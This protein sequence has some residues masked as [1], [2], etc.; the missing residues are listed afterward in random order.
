MGLT[1]R[2]DAWLASRRVRDGT[3]GSVRILLA[4]ALLAYAWR[5]Q[6]LFPALN[7]FKPVTLITGAFFLLLILD[8]K[9]PGRLVRVAQRP[10]AVFAV[11]V[12]LVA[13]VGIPFSLYPGMS[14][15]VALKDV[16]PTVLVAI[17]IA[18]VVRSPRDA[19]RFAGVHVAGAVVYSAVVLSR[20]SLGPDGRLGDLVYYDANGLGLIM[21]CTLPLAYWYA[22][23]GTRWAARVGAVAAMPLFLIAIIRSGSRGALLGLVTVVG[24]TL[25]ANRS[26]TMRTRAGLAAVAALLLLGGGT[27]YWGMMDTML[28]PTRDY[29]WVGNAEGGRMDVW[30]R[31]IGY[32]ASHPILGVGAGAFPVAEGTISPLAGRQDYGEGLKWSA[33]HNSFVQVGAELGV[34]GLVAFLAFLGAGFRQARRTVR[35]ARLIGDLRAAAMGDALAAS[36]AGFAVS[37]FFLS[38]GYSPLAY[39]VVAIA[40]GLNSSLAREL[41]TAGRSAHEVPARSRAIAVG[42]AWTPGGS[43]QKPSE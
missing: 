24:Y 20:F 34:I 35:I 17:G 6:D 5:I 31:G 2:I 42:P 21:V 16:V 9:L 10:P 40:V 30:V 1:A 7:P 29:N 22:L 32:M 37:G 36:L 12:G 13:V 11:I 15:D 8:S 14:F 41:V 18:A 19:Y 28:H 39:S 4:A 3:W 25:V 43:R 38:E 26:A 33:A 23:H 27:K